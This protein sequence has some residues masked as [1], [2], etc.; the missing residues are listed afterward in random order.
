MSHHHRERRHRRA[1]QRRRIHGYSS[2]EAALILRFLGDV[3][4]RLNT[5]AFD[6]G[7]FER[8]FREIGVPLGK[9]QTTDPEIALLQCASRLC[10]H[11]HLGRSSFGHGYRRL[12]QFV[13]KDPRRLRPFCSLTS[14]HGIWVKVREEKITLDHVADLS[15]DISRAY[16]PYVVSKNHMLCD[17][18]A[19]GVRAVCWHFGTLADDAANY[20]HLQNGTRTVNNNPLHR[21]L[22]RAHPVV[23]PLPV[24]PE[25]VLAEAV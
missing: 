18:E 1:R 12:F 24:P 14:L 16:G 25:M 11:F 20:I 17:P 2:Q 19:L 9:L 15:D 23:L 6:V 10:Q 4:S 3:F 5:G 7:A 22:E 8:F 13:E 21:F